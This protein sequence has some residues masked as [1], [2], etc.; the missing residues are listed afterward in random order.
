MRTTEADS[1]E[2]AVLGAII[3]DARV[4]GDVTATIRPDDLRLPHHADLLRLMV[5]RHKRGDGIG[6][7]ELPEAV[8]MS[9]QP[10]RFGGVS[11]V[12]S[13]PDECPALASLPYYLRVVVEAARRRQ[14]REVIHVLGER[15]E[16]G[17][18]SDDMIAEV[19]GMLQRVATYGQ[20]GPRDLSELAA[21]VLD[22]MERQQ[23]GDRDLLPM[24]T[25]LDVLDHVLAGGLRRGELSVVGA[26]PGMGKTALAVQIAAQVAREGQSALVFS[27]E[28]TGEA[29]AERILADTAAMPLW[30]VRQPERLDD[31]DWV[32]LVAAEQAL[33]PYADRFFVDDRAQ[34]TLEQIRGV[35]ERHRAA[36]G[37]LDLVVIDY[38]QILGFGDG[39][40]RVRGMDT[41]ST[42]LMRLAKE[43]G[44]H[45]LLLSQ[46]N[47]NITSRAEQLPTMADLKGCGQLEQDAHLI[48]LPHRPA[49]YDEE[50]DEAE[51]VLII[52]KNRSGACGDV[53]V[54]WNGPLVRFE[55]DNRFVE[56]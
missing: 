15:L 51:S 16:A 11:Y 26:R 29:L 4:L 43:L 18:D 50:A 52:A 13:L 31:Q 41:M 8:A 21:S 45:V 54:R 34:P 2:R 14:L 23:K 32:D 42:G 3:R 46:L 38:F 19:S 10:D 30:K 36:A 6:M 53:D 56:G 35:A 5:A 27:C 7:I 39:H 28:M 12:M 25:G 17:A 33:G 22:R 24:P 37:G 49:V 47:R 1:A 48:I 44:C 40:D 9:G 55:N 20:Q